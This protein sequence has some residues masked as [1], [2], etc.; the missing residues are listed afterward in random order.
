MTSLILASTSSHKKK[1]LRSTG[2]TFRSVDS[3]V[4]ES[5]ITRKTPDGL[6][7]ALSTAKARAVAARYPDAIV[8]GGDTVVVCQRQI[9]GKPHTATAAARMLH[10]ISGQTIT[11]Y[12]GVTI[13][14]TW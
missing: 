1:L 13:V 2:L 12:S 5:R 11:V 6:V 3:G 9:L 14:H 8:I 7:R 10:S 4:D